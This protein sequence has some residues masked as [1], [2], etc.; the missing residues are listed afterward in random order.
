MKLKIGEVAKVYLIKISAPSTV[1]RSSFKFVGYSIGDYHQFP[2]VTN[3]GIMKFEKINN[4]GQAQLFQ[5]RY[6]EV[7]TKTHPLVIW[8][9]YLPVIIGLLYYS[10]N[11][12]HFSLARMFL[13]FVAGGFFLDLF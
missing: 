13:V 12:L 11:T 7:L 1:F 3:L 10:V 8:G 9:L 5:N 4:K 2:V 6:L